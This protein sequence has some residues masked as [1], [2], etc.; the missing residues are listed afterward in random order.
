M[1]NRDIAY[2]MIIIILLSICILRDPICYTHRS[3]MA[4]HGS[5]VGN[6]LGLGHVQPS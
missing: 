5:T 4:Y 3:P 2:I 1:N 6:V